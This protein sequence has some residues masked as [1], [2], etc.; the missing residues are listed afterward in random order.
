MTCYVMTSRQTADQK[1]V[2]SIPITRVHQ[3]SIHFPNF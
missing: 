2:M 3:V 1:E